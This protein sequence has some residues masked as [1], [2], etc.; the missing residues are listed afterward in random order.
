MATS[1][2]VL[3]LDLSDFRTAADLPL[4]LPTNGDVIRYYN[5]VKQNLYGK[6]KSE[7]SVKIIAVKVAEA[8]F[9]RWTDYWPKFLQPLVQGFDSVKVK[10]ERLLERA[11][12]VTS[13]QLKG[14]TK[15]IRSIESEKHRLFSLLSC[16]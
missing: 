15:A 5:L 14:S 16:R 11:V 12:C 1:K 8:V 13:P 3:D 2:A 7:K 6:P 4:K 9:L 10:T